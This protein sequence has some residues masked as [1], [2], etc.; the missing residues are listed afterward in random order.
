[1]VAIVPDGRNHFSR[2]NSPSERN[3]N[4]PTTVLLSFQSLLAFHRPFESTDHRA[5]DDSKAVSIDNTA[6]RV[7][8]SDAQSFHEVTVIVR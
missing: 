6:M 7:S 8:D 3:F 5:A 1:M 2:V 4:C